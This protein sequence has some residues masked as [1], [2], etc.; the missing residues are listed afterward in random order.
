VTHLRHVKTLLF[1]KITKNF[2]STKTICEKRK[3]FYKTTRKK[4]LSIGKVLE[5]EKKYF[6]KKNIFFKFV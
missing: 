4:D 3:F 2:F 6:S 5:T 1:K